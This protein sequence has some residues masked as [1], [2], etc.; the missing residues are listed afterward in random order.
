M[1]EALIGYDECAF[2]GL[3]LVAE[4]G[5]LSSHILISI[6]LEAALLA[7]MSPGPARR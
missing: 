2:A 4:A 1:K 5:V 7:G 3:P 6:R